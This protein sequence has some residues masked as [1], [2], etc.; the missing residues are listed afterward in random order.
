VNLKQR[1]LRKENR[2]SYLR[3]RYQQIDRSYDP[4]EGGFG[5]ASFATSDAQFPDAILCGILNAN[6]VNMRLK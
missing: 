1:Q 6:Q 4:K 2:C 5:N 3:C